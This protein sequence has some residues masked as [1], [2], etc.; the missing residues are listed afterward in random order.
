MKTHLQIVA[1]LH[2]AFGVLSLIFALVVFASLGVA[3]GIALTQGE[4]EAGGIL[5]IIALVLGSFL[6]LLA[7]PGIIGGW[8][9]YTERRWARPVMLV[10]A[11]LQLANIPFGTALGIYTLWALLSDP[12]PQLPASQG[13]QPIT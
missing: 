11:I 10:L 6:V 8:A 5:G 7:L 3:G 9:L 1:A 2:I 13:L 12:Q 4:E